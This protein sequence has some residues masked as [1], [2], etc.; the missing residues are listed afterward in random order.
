MYWR[1]AGH[2]ADGESAA[3]DLAVGREVGTD[4]EEGLSAAGCDAEARDHLVED[5]RAFRRRR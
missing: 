3:H 5:Q 2:D 4:V 1:R